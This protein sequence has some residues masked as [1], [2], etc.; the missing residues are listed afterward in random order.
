MQN[1]QKRELKSKIFKGVAIYS[2]I[3][4][5]GFLVFFISSLLVAGISEF[6]RYYVKVDIEITEKLIQN[7]YS[8]VRH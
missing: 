1:Q 8:L 5:I 2:F 3:F 6:K 7:P 4:C